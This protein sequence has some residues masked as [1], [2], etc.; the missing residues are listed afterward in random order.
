M[1][2]A[3]GRDVVGDGI[4][5]GDAVFEEHGGEA[6]PVKPMPVSSRK[7]RRETPGQRWGV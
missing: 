4:A 1:G 5:A 3:I 2:F 7:E 6:R